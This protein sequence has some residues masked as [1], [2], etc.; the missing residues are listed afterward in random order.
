MQRRREQRYDVWESVIVT[1][2]DEP[3]CRFN[4]ATVVDISRSGY[5]MLSSLDLTVGKEVLITLNSIA[6]IGRVRYC[7]P[8]DSDL[9]STGVEITA[10]KG[11]V[12]TPCLSQQTTPRTV[13]AL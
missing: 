4:A 9:W 11:G 3:E 8:M 7:N 10:V 6:I 2:L 13:P 5:R 1:I 12:S